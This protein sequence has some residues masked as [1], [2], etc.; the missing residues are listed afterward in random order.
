VSKQTHKFQVQVFPF[1][2]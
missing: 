2:Q 1:I